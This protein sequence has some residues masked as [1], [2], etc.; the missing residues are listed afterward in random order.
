MEKVPIDECMNKY[1]EFFPNSSLDRKHICAGNGD[2]D[3]CTGDSGG[4]LLVERNGRWTVIG[5]TSFGVGCGSDVFP[6][7]YTN[8][9]KYITWIK[10]R[11]L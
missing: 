6:G 3:A 7:V 11:A 10:R 2:T 8:V 5:V 4:P 9:A 1:S